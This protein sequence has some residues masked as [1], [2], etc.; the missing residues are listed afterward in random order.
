[1]DVKRIGLFLKE[2]R[3]EKQITQEE[4]AEKLGVSNRTVSRWE[5]GSNMPDFDV[6]IELS[7]FYDVEIREIL[8]GKKIEENS[9][10][11][12]ELL[13]IA[14]YNNKE[15]NK[16]T[17]M[18]RILFLVGLISMVVYLFI[19]NINEIEFFSQFLLGIIF[20]V[21]LIGLLFTTKYMIKI[22]ELKLRLLNRKRG[23][24]KNDR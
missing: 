15:K 21:L 7:D 6:L 11:K 4:L 12:E 3:N 14:D 23:G 5:T 1:M 13:L 8:E 2:L 16:L 22:R 24:N 17:F 18:I 19:H 9:N 10:S 20:A